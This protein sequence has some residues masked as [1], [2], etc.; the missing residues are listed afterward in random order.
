[1]FEDICV[2]WKGQFF[3]KD[4]KQNNFLSA[5]KPNNVTI[6]TEHYEQTTGLLPV[7][8]TDNVDGI[9][10]FEVSKS[11]H[12]WV[13]GGD[14]WMR[15]GL[16]VCIYFCVCVCVRFVLMLYFFMVAHKAA[17]QTLSKIAQENA[18]QK[19]DRY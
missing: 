2:N 9:I 3:N 14:E 4:M 15:G 13:E 16:S 19:S 6:I 10:K 8:G 5:I 18:L 1:M 11:V 17:C 12:V 7:S